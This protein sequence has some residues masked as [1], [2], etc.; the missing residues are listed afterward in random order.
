MLEEKGDGFGG[1]EDRDCGLVGG[2]CRICPDTD[3]V[4][5]VSSE[6]IIPLEE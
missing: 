2:N 1:V 3:C 4:S 6:K 5:N